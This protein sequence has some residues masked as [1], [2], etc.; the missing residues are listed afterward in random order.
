MQPSTDLGD[1]GELL[2]ERMERM[3]A[4]LEAQFAESAR[5]EQ[6]IRENLTGLSYE[7]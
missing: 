2:E 5:L 6:V 1:D 4:E 3:M 7:E